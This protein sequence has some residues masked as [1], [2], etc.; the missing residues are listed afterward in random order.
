MP[1]HRAISTRPSA[2]AAVICACAVLKGCSQEPPLAPPDQTYTL[3]G[4]IETLP[5]AG[6]PMSELTIHHEPLP[7][8]RDANG[9]VVGMTAMVMPFTPTKTLDLQLFAPGD[10]VEFTFEVRWKSLPYS[11]LT[12]MTKLAS[13]TQ[14]NFKSPD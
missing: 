9:E 13:D 1:H 2:L 7:S 5:Q 12:R 14:L 6:K 4:R 8:F 3:R 10:V 11:R